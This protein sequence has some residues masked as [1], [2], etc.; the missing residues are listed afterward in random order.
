MSILFPEFSACGI[1]VSDRTKRIEKTIDR[2]LDTQNLTACETVFESIFKE[3]SGSFKTHDR[4]IKKLHLKYQGSDIAVIVDFTKNLK[5]A[6]YFFEKKHE[7]FFGFKRENS[8]ILISS[9]SMEIIES[10]KILETRPVFSDKT[11]ACE[12][13]VDIFFNDQYVRSKIYKRK[14]L[15]PGFEVK[16]PAL[17]IEK[18][19]T[20]L[21]WSGW[22]AHIRS[23]GNLFLLS[24]SLKR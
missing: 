18:T 5:Q 8:K 1:G 21:V 16:G 14:H 11:P 13:T 22:T 9:V 7:D 20:N 3:P 10:S 24:L 2:S 15:I 23:S 17:I 19:G 4:I 12:K 6:V